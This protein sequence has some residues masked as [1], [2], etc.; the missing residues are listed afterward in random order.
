MCIRDRFSKVS[1]SW[2]AKHIN[3]S[4]LVIISWLQRLLAS[5]KGNSSFSLFSTKCIT[6]SSWSLISGNCLSRLCGSKTVNNEGLISKT[7]RITAALTPCDPEVRILCPSSAND[8]A[9]NS[10][11]WISTT[12]TCLLPK[13]AILLFPL[14]WSFAS[15]WAKT[16]TLRLLVDLKSDSK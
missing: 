1:L 4:H 2:K 5:G 16:S 10:I 14:S 11:K 15:S 7:A 12:G 13:K 6:L 8:L 9:I 3:W